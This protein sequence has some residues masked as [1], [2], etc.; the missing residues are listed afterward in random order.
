MK[1]LA[2]SGTR[3]A[4]AS[5]SSPGAEAIEK[6]RRLPRASERCGRSSSSHCP[7]SKC[8]GVRERNRYSVT[9]GAIVS[10][11]RSSSGSRRRWRY[12]KAKASALPTTSPSSGLE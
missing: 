6:V 2:F 10:A 7:A 9:P 4:I 8:S 12:A 1:L 5:S 3:I 11:E